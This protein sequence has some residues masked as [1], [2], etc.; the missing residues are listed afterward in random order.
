MR[1]GVAAIRVVH[2]TEMKSRLFKENRE[3]KQVAAAWHMS[4]TRNWGEGKKDD[5]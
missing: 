5:G 4:V 3:L 1:L 2:V